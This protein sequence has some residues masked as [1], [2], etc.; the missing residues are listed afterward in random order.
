MD[1]CVIEPD[2]FREAQMKC[3]VNVINQVPVL[4]LTAPMQSGPYC[5]RINLTG[6]HGLGTA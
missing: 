4:P 6:S 5:R 3:E 2:T 1:T